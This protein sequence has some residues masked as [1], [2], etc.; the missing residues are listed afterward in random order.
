MSGQRQAP[1]G[2][3]GIVENWELR[4]RKSRDAN[5]GAFKGLLFVG[6]ALVLI[7]VGG[8]YAT[9]PMVGPFL[10]DTFE[11]HPGI[12]N[13]PVVSDLIAAE[14]SD[15]LDKPASAASEEVE[16]VIEPGQTVD[17]IQTTVAAVTANGGAIA[18]EPFPIPGV[19]TTAVVHDP[20]HGA[21]QL[22]QPEG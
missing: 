9:R 19:G 16:F 10:T 13:Y 22:M 6:V 14:F 20:Q 7:T 11:D 4:Q 12:I 21:F 17:D 3:V 8:W 18:Q 2:R 5:S 1:G 15:R